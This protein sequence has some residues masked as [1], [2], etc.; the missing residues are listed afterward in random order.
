M[1]KL[2]NSLRKLKLHSKLLYFNINS[3]YISTRTRYYIDGFHSY[4]P[5]TI[6][7]LWADEIA[8]NATPV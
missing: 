6:A 2:L 5:Q 7:V 8:R 3:L 1:Q 4:R